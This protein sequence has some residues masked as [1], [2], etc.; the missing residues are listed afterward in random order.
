MSHLKPEDAANALMAHLGITT[1]AVI[2]PTEANIEHF[3]PLGL[4]RET[5]LLL[6]QIVSNIQKAYDEK[7]ATALLSHDEGQ[8]T[9]EGMGRLYALLGAETLKYSLLSKY[10]IGEE[11]KAVANIIKNTLGTSTPSLGI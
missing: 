9:L 5:A 8:R 3:R 2:A 6:A 4:T 11:R 1:T 10:K 7:K